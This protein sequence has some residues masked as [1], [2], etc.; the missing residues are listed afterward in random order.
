MI[1]KLSILFENKIITNRFSIKLHHNNIIVDSIEIN[2]KILQVPIYNKYNGI[3]YFTVN[4]PL[5]LPVI[6]NTCFNPYLILSSYNLQMENE[7]DFFYQIIQVINEKFNIKALCFKDILNDKFNFPKIIN[8]YYL[9][10]INFENL[11]ELDNLEKLL[12]HYGLI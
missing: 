4:F 12:V 5:I 8:D 1:Q 10:S 3:D 6:K 7:I 2:N 9:E 11:K